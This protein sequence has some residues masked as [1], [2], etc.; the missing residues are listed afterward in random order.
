MRSVEVEIRKGR[1]NSRLL[2]FYNS[3]IKPVPLIIAS[4]DLAQ[5]HPLRVSEIC[6]VRFEAVDCR[7]SS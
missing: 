3:Q 2:H 4:R 1:C 5:G 7:P 6:V